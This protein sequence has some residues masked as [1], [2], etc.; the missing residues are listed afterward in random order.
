MNMRNNSF[1]G[2][3]LIFLLLSHAG[4]GKV[5]KVSSP[6]GQIKAEVEIGKHI[7][8]RV[9]KN[10][11]LLLE[12][13]KMAMRTSD[14]HEFGT[15]PKV[16]RTTKN[17]VT[18]RIEPVVPVKNKYIENHYNELVISFRDNYDLI[19]RAYNDGVAYKFRCS[20]PAGK[21]IEVI[22]ETVEFNFAGNHRLFWPRETHPTFQSHYENTYYDIHLNELTDEEYGSLPVLLE[23]NKGTKIL[24]TEADVFDYPNLFLFGKGVNTLQ[25]KFPN[26]VLEVLKVGDRG[27]EIAKQAPYIAKTSGQRSFPW[28][29]II[30]AHEDKQLLENEMVFKLSTPN[31]FTGTDW[32]KP[33]KVAWDWWNANNVYGVDFKAGINTET[34]K[35]FIDF[36]SQ[37]GLEYIILDEGWS[38]TTTD[39]S[40][41]IPEIDLPELFR[42]AREKNTGI[43]LWVLWNALDMDIEGTLD[44][45]ASWGAKGIKVDFMARADQGMVNYYERVSAAA[46]DRKLL[47]NFHGAYKPAGLNR[48]YPNV[49]SFEGVKGL[50]W[51]KW[52]ED[53][54]PEHNV[55]L[56]FIRMVA[57]PMDYTPGAMVNSSKDN[58]C[59]RFSEP[60]SQGSRAHQ[61]A[62]YVMYESP[63][64]MLADNPSSYMREPEY[65][66][67]IAQMPVVWDKT[68][69]LKSSIGKYAAIA[70]KN[71]DKWYIA[72]MT[73]WDARELI[74]DTDF[75][76][77][78]T[79]RVDYIKDGMN[80]DRFGADYVIGSKILSPNETITVEMKSGGGW[81]AILT[82]MD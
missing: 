32:I 36:A 38:I 78:K 18:E 59:V 31:E 64:Q 9:Y 66:R 13:S 30:I 6:D 41:S 8:W 23:T 33:G 57:G 29:V 2:V 34:Y 42:Y 25:G 45:F 81:I 16:I 39:L 53:I 74:I 47:V 65:T 56:P 51:H 17:L 4:Y 15:N 49:L 40:Q 72:A 44:R 58:F 68:V 19:F 54:T 24:L 7:S 50:E 5:Y 35:Y 21:Q 26:A 79:Y 27:E 1:Y 48:K 14:N 10:D 3:L 11:E 73:N 82:P 69:G 80:A 60:M 77:Q 52:S 67:F 28:R 76:E 63:M 70:R 43:V 62:M 71:G 22:S 46:F 12:P 75:L 37:Y 61:A 20:M 55:T